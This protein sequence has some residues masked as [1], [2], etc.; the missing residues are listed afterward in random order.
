[1]RCH[2]YPDLAVHSQ[3]KAGVLQICPYPLV[4]QPVHLASHQVPFQDLYQCLLYL[5]K[6]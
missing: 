2:Y 5:Q 4:H 1:M 3:E 6:S